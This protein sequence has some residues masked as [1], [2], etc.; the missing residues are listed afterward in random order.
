M[1]SMHTIFQL[2]TLN[3]IAQEIRGLNL[4]EI[5]EVKFRKV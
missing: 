3:P 2:M 1:E 5:F 4:F